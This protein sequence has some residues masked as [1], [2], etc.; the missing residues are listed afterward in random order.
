MSRLNWALMWFAIMALLFCVAAVSCGD[1]DDDDDDS[2]GDDD[3]GSDDDDV[4]DDDDSDPGDPIEPTAGYLSRQAEYLTYCNDNNGPGQGGLHGQVC[5]AYTSAGTFNEEAITEK[6]DMINNREDTADFYLTSIIRLLL[7]DRENPTLPDPLKTEM[8]NAVLDFKYWLDEPGPDTMC[9]W[10]ENHQILFHACELLAGQLFPDTVFSNSGMTGNEHIDHAVPLLHRW[11]DFRAKFGFSEFHSNVYFNEDMPPLI[12]LVDFAEPENIS[13]KAS[14]VLDILA[15]D[16]GMNYYKGLFA[17]THGRT[18]PSKLLGGLNDSTDEAAWILLGLGDYSSANDFTG[19][20][21]ATSDFYWPPAILEDIAADSADEIEHKQRDSIDI[22]DGPA[23]GI[24]YEDYND[25]MFWWGMQGHAA[26][27]TIQSTFQMVEDFDMWNGFM[28]E[29]VKF[30]RIFLGSPLLDFV[31]DTWEEMALGIVLESVNTYTYRTPH[32]QLSGAQDYKPG[33]WTA[34]LHVWQATLDKDAYVFTTYPGSMAELWTGGFTPRATTHKNVGIFQYRRPSLPILD[35]L[36]FVD[37]SHAYFP[38]LEFDEV[39]ENG[40]WI[41]GQKGDAY[42]ALYSHTPTTWSLDNDYELIANSK[43][44]DWI[45]ELG[46]LPESGSFEDFVTAVSNATLSIN[47]NG[48][49]YESPSLGMIT[50]SYEGSFVVDGTTID[51]SPYKR[52]DNKY[53]TQEF[54]TIRTI[55]EFDGQRLDLNFE[56]PSRRYWESYSE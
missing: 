36:L 6:L 53:C 34:Q 42:V 4:V 29:D 41:F 40:N 37:Y 50:V 24:G 51:T 8:E 9:W 21:L 31:A 5:R 16:M 2:G 56:D 17:T 19:S 13:L 22:D 32:Y 25:I 30:L 49:S 48:I 33:S 11:L 46:S 45:V 54:G 55:V 10:T 28:W 43:E 3:N 18:Y 27:Q 7:I 15:M 23:Y 1:D 52:W 44:N 39:V 47:G 14:M 26:P 38:K 20:Y 35:D 12:N